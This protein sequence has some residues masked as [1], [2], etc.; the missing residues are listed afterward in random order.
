MS[1]NLFLRSTSSFDYYCGTY[2]SIF[3][4]LQRLLKTQFLKKKAT[5]PVKKNIWPVLTRFI[6][7]DKPQGTTYKGLQAILT[8][9]V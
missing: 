1:G 2:K 5:F 9:I 8:N 4:G 3:F 6:V 7:Y